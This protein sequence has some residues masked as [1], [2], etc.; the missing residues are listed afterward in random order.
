MKETLHVVRHAMLVLLLLVAVATP[1]QTAA[2]GSVEVT[3]ETT[4]GTIRLLLYDAT[5]LHRDNFVK[6]V[7]MHVYD[8]VLFHRVIEGFMIQGGDP[9]S[10]YAAPGQLLG[11]GDFDYTVPAEMRLPQ[12][13]HRRGSLAM[14]RESDDVNPDRASSACQF[15]IVWGKTFSDDELDRVQERLDTLYGEPVTLTDEMRA[16]YKTVG[17]TPHLDGGYT[18]FGEVTQGIE[19]VEA[20]QR[21]PTDANDRP[22]DDVRIVRAVVSKK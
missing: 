19:V 4:A 10:R 11:N 7:S 1:A 2:E 15:Y 22:L 20:I 12:I 6:L 18:V 3:L 5:P 16:V 8:S 17:G 21:R 14:A 13:Y 9:T